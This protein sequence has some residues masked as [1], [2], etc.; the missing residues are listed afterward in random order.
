MRQLDFD[1]TD[2]ISVVTGGTSGI[3]FEIARNFCMHGSK[4]TI[5]GRGAAKGKA[6]EI[7]IRFSKFKTE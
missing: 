6:A 7:S 1:L 3:G 5:I 2:K 4:T